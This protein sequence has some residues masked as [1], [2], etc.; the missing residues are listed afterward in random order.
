LSRKSDNFNI[1]RTQTLLS[2][3][4]KW[5]RFSHINKKSK[6]LETAIQKFNDE[7]Q[8]L[9]NGLLFIHIFKIFVNN[10]KN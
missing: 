4:I 6:A 3:A 5:K 9:K 8:E 1:D 7:V 10:K 2:S